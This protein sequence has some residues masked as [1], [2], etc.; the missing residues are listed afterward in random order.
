[1]KV[2][3]PFYLLLLFALQFFAPVLSR[4]QSVSLHDST[5]IHIEGPHKFA[6]VNGITGLH[7]TSLH[8][9]AWIESTALQSTEGAVSLW[10][11]P[12]EDIDKSPNVQGSLVYPLISDKPQT[13]VDDSTHFSIYYQ[14]TGYPRLIARFIFRSARKPQMGA[15]KL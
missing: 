14:G 4:A 11:S 6:A 7:V 10:M 13:V 5:G 2:N 12:L 8:T 9:N 1:M 15:R 3:S